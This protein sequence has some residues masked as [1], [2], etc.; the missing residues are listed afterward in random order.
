LFLSEAGG[1]VTHWDRT[2]Y[3]VGGP[4]KG[5]LCAANEHLWQVAAEALLGMEAGLIETEDCIS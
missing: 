5:V 2:P 3:R 1:M 4:G